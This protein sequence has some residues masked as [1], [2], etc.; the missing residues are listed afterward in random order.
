[1]EKKRSYL[2]VILI[3]ILFLLSLRMIH[4]A[5]DPPD[6]LSASGGP[7]GDPGGY[8]FH[9]R[10]KI[11]FGQWEIDKMNSPLYSSPIPA[12]VTYLSF[13]LFG[14]GF[15]QM[16]LVPI[17]FSCLTLIF[18]FLLL[19][20]TLNGSPSLGIIAF[21]L[22]GLDYLFLMYSRIAN[23]VMPM[24][25]FLVLSLFFFQK[26][27]KDK[28][29]YF[30]AGAS[31]FLAFATKGVCFYV[32]GAFFLGF[33]VH[34]VLEHGWKKASVP[35]GLYLAGFLLVFLLW[36][37]VIYI[38]HT[39]DLR[40]ISS[41]NVSF[42]I[43]PKSL[44]KILY[45]FWIRP[46][47]LLER[48]PILSVLSSF[49]LL[50]FLSRAAREPKKIKLLEWIILFWFIASVIY[51]S[52]IQQRV[53]RH[54]IPQLIPMVF[55]SAWFIQSF[56]KSGRLTKPRR[57]N[58]FFGMLLFFWLL[59]PL[60]KILKP[61]LDRLPSAFSNIWIATAI[62]AAVSVLVVVLAFVLI[63]SWPDSFSLSFTPLAKKIILVLVFLGVIFFNGKPYL[64]WALHPKF[65]LRNISFDLG[66]AFDHA[67]IS[68][69]WAPVISLENKHRA[70]ES[71]PGFVNDEKDFLEKFQVTHVFAST[72][73]NNQEIDYY[74]RNFPEAMGKARLLAKYPV[75]RT[76]MLLYDLKPP[77]GPA[78][79]EH[80]YEA[81]IHTRRRGL[82][83][84]DPD[85]SGRFSV[86]SEKG[87]PGFVAVVPL[88]E[89]IPGG[90]YTVTF[91]MKRSTGSSIST[92]R[93]ARIDAVSPDTRRLLKAKNLSREDFPDT[94]A[95]REFA[96][97]ID[98][99]RPD[100]LSFRVYADG[101]GTFWVDWIKI[102]KIS[103][104]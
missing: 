104:V 98:L 27:A 22:L 31:S 50:F 58:L 44:S 25:F 5:A 32:V 38:P 72:A 91:R 4:P 78:G 96:L 12:L 55:L 19:R 45:Y 95:Y 7:F 68:G 30:L 35:F 47:L 11:L 85:A 36:M 99:K 67:V 14:I 28:K 40:S 41:I 49:S 24:I 82:P 33:F 16:N 8:A 6:N 62:L 90:R 3:V 88:P 71:F 2:L 87:N 93:I 63:R 92:A 18:V 54:F 80:H 73:F 86:L 53:T 34:L 51:F 94:D 70:H 17:L 103:G 57:F 46:S 48:S 76:E 75:W 101:T 60:S 89:K 42:L 77:E 10:N 26:G 74:R 79:Q 81:E 84:F 29:W 23:R 100:K 13:K 9:A 52:I 69:L 43:P 1:M 102:E 61:G 15:I 37:I 65:K 59:F 39:D 66:E 21:A 64:A 83:R 56:L 20:D 97:P